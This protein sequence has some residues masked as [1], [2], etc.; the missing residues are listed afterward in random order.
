[1]ND[2][3]SLFENK[4]VDVNKAGVETLRDGVVGIGQV[5]AER[6]VGYREEHGVFASLEELEQVSGI[7]P[8]KS[9][10][11]KSWQLK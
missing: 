2:D 6:I 8:W 11:R 10:P 4:P 7:G 1:M 3:T 9:P 5:L